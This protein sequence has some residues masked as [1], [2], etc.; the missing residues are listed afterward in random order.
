VSSLQPTGAE[1]DVSLYDQSFYAQGPLPQSTWQSVTAEGHALAVRM[2][3]NV[4]PSG[5]NAGSVFDTGTFDNMVFDGF[6]GQTASILQV[7]AFNAV[8]EA[9]NYI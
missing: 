9:G 7:N 2:K 3:V 8:I 6:S 4:L 1:Y 5:G